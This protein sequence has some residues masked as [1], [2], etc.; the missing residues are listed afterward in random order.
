MQEGGSLTN[1]QMD[2]EQADHVHTLC[3]I[4]SKQDVAALV[5]QIE[6]WQQQKKGRRLIDIKMRQ[7]VCVE[8]MGECEPEETPGEDEDDDEDKDEL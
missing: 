8:L 6:A 7:E 4:L 2:V 3:R 5:S 1:L